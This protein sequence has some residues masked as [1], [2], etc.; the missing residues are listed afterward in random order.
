MNLDDLKKIWPKNNWP[1]TNDELMERYFSD[2]L[3]EEPKEEDVF[4]YDEFPIPLI[5]GKTD[6]LL[7]K[8]NFVTV[9]VKSAKIIA[10]SDSKTED[11]KYSLYVKVCVSKENDDVLNS[12]L[13]KRLNIKK[14]I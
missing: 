7:E 1:P 8:L 5:K 9:Y 6:E 4:C 3:K 2:T 12:A 11:D 10:N 13:R 14:P